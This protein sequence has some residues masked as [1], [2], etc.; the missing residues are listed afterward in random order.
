MKVFI[1]NISS[2]HPVIDLIRKFSSAAILPEWSDDLLKI[3]RQKCLVFAK[4]DDIETFTRINK[5][6][7]ENG[8]WCFIWA[9]RTLLKS[10]SAEIPS[11]LIDF[12][13]GEYDENEI[14]IRLIRLLRLKELDQ[15]TNFFDIPQKIAD[16]LTKNQIMLFDELYKAGVSGVKKKY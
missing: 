7:E 14:R 12:I 6:C 8:Q 11:R 10:I 9:D 3:Y 1:V 13:S 16:E 15:T 4:V 5:A 2:S